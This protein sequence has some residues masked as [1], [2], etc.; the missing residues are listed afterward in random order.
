[1]PTEVIQ[2]DHYHLSFQTSTTAGN[3]GAVDWFMNLGPFHGTPVHRLPNH[4][5]SPPVSPSLCFC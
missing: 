1:M 2:R 3:A 4:G 5:G